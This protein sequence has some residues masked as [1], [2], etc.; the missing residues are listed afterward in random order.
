MQMNGEENPNMMYGDEEME[1][2]GAETNQ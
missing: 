2:G 1:M